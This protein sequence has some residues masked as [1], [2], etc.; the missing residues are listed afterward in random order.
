MYNVNYLWVKMGRQI[1]VALVIVAYSEIIVSLLIKLTTVS[2]P[3]T[4]LENIS[5]GF[6]LE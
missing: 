1:H 3:L 2:S 5:V 4:L 6:Y